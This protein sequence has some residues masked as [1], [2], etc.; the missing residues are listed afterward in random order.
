[1]AYAG[2][3]RVLTE[4]IA[5]PW[6]RIYWR[7][8]MAT[9]PIHYFYYVPRRR[10]ILVYWTDMIH[11]TG[12]EEE[13]LWVEMARAD[14]AARRVWRAWI[15]ENPG[16]APWTTATLH[17]RPEGITAA[18]YGHRHFYQMDPAEEQFE[19]EIRMW[20]NI[21]IPY[22]M[23]HLRNAAYSA[24]RAPRAA[25]KR[26]HP[27]HCKPCGY[28]E[29]LPEEEPRYRGLRRNRIPARMFHFDKDK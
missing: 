25:R 13:L 19:W 23:A 28:I 10:N 6:S 12:G 26:P 17:F 3:Q 8:L 4:I 1:M 11:R 24:W 29:A 14:E 7:T 9:E 21:Y 15:E 22:R 27:W 5:E 18:S 20:G 2:L 16:R